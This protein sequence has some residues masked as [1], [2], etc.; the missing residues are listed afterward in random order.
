MRLK[1]L[2]SF[3]IPYKHF[4]HS[5]LF[6]SYSLSVFTFISRG[7]SSF[8]SL[9]FAFFL[10]STECWKRERIATAES[11][12]ELKYKNYLIFYAGFKLILTKLNWS[13]LYVWTVLRNPARVCVRVCVR[14]AVLASA[15]LEF[16]CANW[17]Q[18]PNQVNPTGNGNGRRG[19]G[20]HPHCCLMKKI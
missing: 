20:A 6:V 12:V 5:H 18:S 15:I 10:F 11:E 3:F 17:S 9:F 7:F 1:Y 19:H 13:H 14:V 2:L 8:H 4:S 16:R